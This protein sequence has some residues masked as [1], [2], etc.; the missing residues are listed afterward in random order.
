MLDFDP[1]GYAAFLLASLPGLAAAPVARGRL[2]CLDVALDAAPRGGLGVELGVWRGRSLRRAARRQPWRRFHGFDSLVGFPEDSRPDWRLDFKVA[3]LPR[4]PRNCTFHEGFFETTVPRFVA[5][6][7]EPVAVLNVDCDIHASTHQALTALAPLLGPGAALH[8]D[9]GVN[10]DTWL[11]NEML[12]LFRFLDAR[13]LDMRWIARGGRLRDLPATLRFLEAGRY[14]CWEDDVAA[15]YAR[16]CA[17][18]LVARA[19][20]W[21][22]VPGDMAERLAARA[23]VHLAA[24][25]LRVDCDPDDPFV[26]A[27]RRPAWKRWLGLR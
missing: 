27:P 25:Q 14:P 12:A 7:T 2:G 21:P 19:A 23:R 3:A 20:P 9:E 13:A 26:P 11:F 8:L 16:Q 1:A 4:L 6:A 17:G 10:Y 24:E 18:L 5:D 15:G 22:A